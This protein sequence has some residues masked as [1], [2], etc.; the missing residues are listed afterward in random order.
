MHEYGGKA[1][2]Y[3]TKTAIAVV[4]LIAL[5]ASLVTDERQASAQSDLSNAGE[6]IEGFSWIGSASKSPFTAVPDD[7]VVDLDLP[8]ENTIVNGTGAQIQNFP[9]MV[10]LENGDGSHLCTGTLLR[11]NLVISARHCFENDDL[12]AFRSDWR[13]INV[14]YGTT[15]QSGGST[16]NVADVAYSGRSGANNEFAL[17]LVI[18]ELDK[19]VSLGPNVGLVELA[20][21]AESAQ[22]QNGLV[23]GWGAIG[24]DGPLAQQLRKA[25]IALRSD[26]MCA[27]ILGS[28]QGPPWRLPPY[29]GGRMICGGG[30]GSD[31]CSG[32]S[33]GPLMVRG[34][35]GQWKQ[36]GVTSFGYRCNAGLPGVYVELNAYR[37]A[38]AN[39]VGRGF[40]NGQR[41]TVDLSLGDVPTAGSDRIVG[42]PYKDIV[43]AQ[44]GDD[45]VCGLGGNDVVHGGPGNDRLHGN[46]GWDGL[47]GGP[48]D[49]Q[50]WGGLGNDNIAGGLGNDKLFGGEHDDVLNGYE[51]TDEIY[52]G[53]G[54][55]RISGGP[56][57]GDRCYGLDG[58]DTGLG[59]CEIRGGLEAFE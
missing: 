21:A 52:G 1:L 13:T 39:F 26:A 35:D 41:S 22:A 43:Y 49:D 48:G 17:D 58:Y 14:R 36:A 40:C 5:V 51:G 12:S 37:S 59:G 10:Q 33:G 23:L 56:G 8:P 11:T 25:T 55:D 28:K 7:A 9:W 15:G 6:S 30:S 18:V 32:D 47:F 44:G 24:F 38:L 2:K 54:N 19:H 29:L 53:P 34:T 4:S 50:I 46:R 42:T 3:T 31:T 27:N 45:I 16:R 57:L 20:S